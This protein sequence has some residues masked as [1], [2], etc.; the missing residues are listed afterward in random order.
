MSPAPFWRAVLD[1]FFPAKCP[2]CGLSPD[3]STPDRPCPACL[4]QIKFFSSPRCLHCG[5]GFPSSSE[6]DHLCAECLSE[7]RHFN[8]ARAVCGYEG[9]IME[10]I[11]R[12]KYGG[13]TRLAMPLGN[14]LAEYQD[15]DFELSENDLVIPVP[16]HTRRLQERGFNQ[17]LL[18]ARQVSRRRSIPL[19]FTALHRAR[20]TQPQ[21]QLS[22]AERRKNVRGAFE[23]RK[24]EAVK[25]KRILL[26]DDVFT[27][28]ATVQECAYVLREAG[29]SE[30]HVLTLA[31]VGWGY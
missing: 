13:L 24:R 30:V 3:L 28:G 9:V 20:Q 18:L 2:L 11:S 17:S 10:A 27:T 25:G 6:V 21:T 29:A 7:E 22:G 4:S 8:L 5:I 19:N 12:L 23:V 31:R 15:P 1:F 26:I 14:L 16:L